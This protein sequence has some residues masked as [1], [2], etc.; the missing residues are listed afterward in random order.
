MKFNKTILSIVT[1]IGL[2]SLGG[3]YTYSAQ[4]ASIMQEE[5]QAEIG[6][7]EE[8]PL[9]QISY[10][11][12]SSE[13][14]A[15]GSSVRISDPDITYHIM[16]TVDAKIH[17]DGDV[18]ITNTIISNKYQAKAEG[19]AHIEVTVGDVLPEFPYSKIEWDSENYDMAVA[20]Q[21]GTDASQ[22]FEGSV[23]DILTKLLQLTL[24][25]SSSDSSSATLHLKTGGSLTFEADHSSSSLNQSFG[26]EG[27]EF[28]L[29]ADHVGM[30][31][32]VDNA[33]KVPAT[34]E[35]LVEHLKNVPYAD[36]SSDMAFTVHFKADHKDFERALLQ[37][38]E[39]MDANDLGIVAS[40]DLQT[41]K[42][43]NDKL[44]LKLD[45]E[46]AP[47]GPVTGSWSSNGVREDYI[48]L[49][50]AFCAEVDRLAAAYAK[51]QPENAD[52]E[53]LQHYFAK[54]RLI[55]NVLQPL[56]AI[57][58]F[59]EQSKGSFSV[60]VESNQ[61]QH[62][63]FKLE[64]Y[65]ISGDNWGL[66]LAAEVHY[67]ERAGDSADP[68]D[69]DS[70]LLWEVKVD[71]T[72]HR[73]MADAT[74]AWYNGKVLDLAAHLTGDEAVRA[75]M[76]ADENL[77]KAVITTL[78]FAG[79]MHHGNGVTVVITQ[80]ADG[81]IRIGKLSLEEAQGVFMQ[82]LIQIMQEQAG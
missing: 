12:I 15:T 81:D 23:E 64:Q 58:K 69:M 25:E 53:L 42:E 61:D 7:L 5:I 43:P 55:K 39:N 68:M 2:V 73:G 49:I 50:D 41:S 57:G 32:I 45:V 62:A 24:I 9:V 14:T 16:P 17:V 30:R 1:A 74:L 71:T 27:Y 52:E 18:V 8:N 28:T 44:T 37:G 40:I 48:A 20:F 36:S 80:K 46:K 82:N 75:E 10:E 56:K 60:K 34:L 19:K 78:E 76:Y 72:N 77:V 26:S 47:Q 67:L 38:F 66:D 70:Q 13:A 22:L 54:P 11:S 29:K 6:K 31:S 51:M 63:T 33:D 59:S 79:E 4:K 3:S 21:S 65:Q 35:D